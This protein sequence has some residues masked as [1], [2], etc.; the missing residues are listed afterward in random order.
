MPAPA[1]PALAPL[2]GQEG[3]A[4]A[5]GAPA[6][7]GGGMPFF[8]NPL[9]LIALM[10]LFFLVV[11]L[12]A[13]RRQKREA[14]QMLANLKAGSKVIVGGGIVGTIVK[15]KDGEDEIVVKSE[16]AKLRFLRSSIVRVLSDDAATTTETK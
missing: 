15:I 16:D 3:I 11:M 2:L 12:P 9:F 14:A 7:E 13:Q 10:G 4:P 6:A 8:A 1:P 5:A